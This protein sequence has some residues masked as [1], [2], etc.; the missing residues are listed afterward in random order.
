MANNRLHIYCA[1]CRDQDPPEGGNFM[2]AKYYPSDGWYI[3]EDRPYIE[4]FN[5]WAAEHIHGDMWGDFLRVEYE[6][7]VLQETIRA[8]HAETKP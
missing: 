5:A 3:R 2:L 6:H 1:Y 8:R 7:D 4:Q